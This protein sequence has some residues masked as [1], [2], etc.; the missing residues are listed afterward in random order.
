[1]RLSTIWLNLAAFTCY[2]SAH[3]LAD[4][5]RLHLVQAALEKEIKDTLASWQQLLARADRIFVQASVSNARPVY[6]GD[7]AALQRHDPR[8]RSI[9]F[10]TRSALPEW[11][12]LQVI[13][14]YCN[15]NVHLRDLPIIADLIPTSESVR[16]KYLRCIHDIAFEV[17][18]C[19]SAIAHV[20]QPEYFQT[21]FA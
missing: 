20:Q 14:H 7:D 19:G 6:G 10:N 15:V 11:N 21:K 13:L 5:A 16:Q 12:R 2:A 17:N 8:I 18:Y 4:P 9:P 3:T 1:M